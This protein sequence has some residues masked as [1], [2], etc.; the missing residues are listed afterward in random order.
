MC[1]GCGFHFQIYKRNG[2]KF[3]NVFTNDD[4]EDEEEKEEE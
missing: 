1:G 2:Y 4:D 3:T